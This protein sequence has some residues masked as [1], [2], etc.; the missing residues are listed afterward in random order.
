M[1][2]IANHAV[3]NGEFEIAK[4]MLHAIGITVKP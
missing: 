1:R 2:S 4:V 3:A